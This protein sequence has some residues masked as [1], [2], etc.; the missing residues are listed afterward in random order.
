MC[1]FCR[2]VAGELPVAKVMET[3]DVLVFLDNAPVNPGHM[4]VIPKKHLATLEE[5]NDELLGALILKVKEA[6]ALLKTKL[7]YSG[8][9]VILNNDPIAGQE[10]PHLH[11]HIIPRVLE[12]T[13]LRFPEK[14]YKP[15]EMAAICEKLNS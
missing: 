11:W 7:G 9:N 15:G 5:L 12:D 14:K 3:E 2:L 13:P 6:G 1:V 8:Y 4:L 10:I